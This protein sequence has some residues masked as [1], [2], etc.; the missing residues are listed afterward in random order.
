MANVAKIEGK[1]LSTAA[2]IALVGGGA[3]VLWKGFT[4]IQDYF[5]RKRTEEATQNIIKSTL[6]IEKTK[7]KIADIER[8]AYVSGVN[9][10]GKQTTVNLVNQVKEIIN[11]YFVTIIDKNGLTKYYPKGEINQDNI[12]KA[13]FNTPVKNLKNLSKIYAIYTGRDFLNDMQK[14]TPKN[15]QSIKAVFTVSFKKYGA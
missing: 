10:Y 13:V 6:S 11:A 8:K 14:L 3:F 1:G 7:G 4:M 2:T 5:S 9:S 15:Y 12:V